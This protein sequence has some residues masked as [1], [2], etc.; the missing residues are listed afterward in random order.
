MLTFLST[1][2]KTEFSSIFERVV[3]WK[4]LAEFLSTVPRRIIRLEAKNGRDLP[5]LTSGCSPLPEDACLRGM[6]WGGRKIYER[7]FWTKSNETPTETEVLDKQ[8]A[9]EPTDGI[10]EDEDETGDKSPAN[11][12]KSRWVRLYRAGVKIAK[13]V[14]GFGSVAEENGKRSWRVEGVLAA[15]VAR[16][17]EIE[18]LEREE[19]EMRRIRK[20]WDDS[21][22]IDEDAVENPFDSED[23][24]SDDDAED[25]EEVK[26]L[27][28]SASI[29]SCFGIV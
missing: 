17:I 26:S 6:A 21:M 20:R 18:R 22:D 8:E 3:P 11:D 4:E 16:W 19:E 9:E 12:Q 10:I 27:R 25:S 13:Y 1:V 2:M 23:D 7:G 14:D 28:V 5:L 15:K 24:D 29:E